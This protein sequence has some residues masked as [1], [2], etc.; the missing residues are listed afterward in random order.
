V[1]ETELLSGGRVEI[2]DTNPEGYRSLI[3]LEHSRRWK[4]DET[5]EGARSCL[6]RASGVSC[7]DFRHLGNFFSRWMI[8]NGNGS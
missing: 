7:A 8:G 1:Q 2:L 5:I 4:G 6:S 3:E